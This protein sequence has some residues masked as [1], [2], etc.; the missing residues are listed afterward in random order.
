MPQ[1]VLKVCVGGW[2]ESEFSNQL[3]LELSLNN[4]ITIHYL[5]EKM[6]IKSLDFTWSRNCQEICRKD[7][8]RLCL[9]SWNMLV[10]KLKTCS[11][12]MFCSYATLLSTALWCSTPVWL[13]YRKNSEDLFEDHS[14]RHVH[15]LFISSR[16]VRSRHIIWQ[17]IQKMPRLLAQSNHA[18]KK[19][20]VVSPGPFCRSN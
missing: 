5:K 3:R 19:Q 18:S 13:H 20:Q 10:L 4:H 17:T 1:S 16:N 6:F 7:Y 14:W 8:S 11:I 15:G 9:Q 2:L 12:S